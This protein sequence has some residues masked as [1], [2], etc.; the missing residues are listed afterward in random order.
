MENDS[1]SD[2]M[3]LY[4]IC[5]RSFTNTAIHFFQ[6]SDIQYVTARYF[7]IYGGYDY[8]KIIAAIPV[9]IQSFLQ[10]KPVVCK[11][12]NNILDYVYV[13]DAAEATIKILESDFCG[14]VNIASGLPRM[15]SG[16]FSE[17]ADILNCRE[18]LSFEHEDVCRYIHV[19]DEDILNTKIGYVCRTDFHEGIR[20]T[21]QWWKDFY[22]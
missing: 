19:G 3:S 6:E 2:P 7:T 14:I 11:Q 9:A 5:K 21:V 18:L 1:V 22:R 17:I 12:P 20:K 8:R 13:D 16:V 10:G 15:M 4:G